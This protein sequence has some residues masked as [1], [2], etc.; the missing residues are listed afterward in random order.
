MLKINQSI[1]QFTLFFSRCG[2]TTQIPQ[3]ILDASLNGPAEQVANVLCTQPR[4]ISAITVAQRV[5]QERAESLG[6]S[7]GY[8]IRLESV[9]VPKHTRSPGFTVALWICNLPTS[10]RR[11]Q[12]EMKAEI[13]TFFSPAVVGHQAA[14]LH[15]RR[16][17]E[18][19]GGWC[20]P[21]GGHARHR[22]WGAR[23][24]RGEVSVCFA[25]KSVVVCSGLLKHFCFLH[26]SLSDFLLLVLKDLIIKRPDL[27]IVLMSATLNANL[28]SE[29]FYNCPTVHIPGLTSSNQNIH[30][31][32]NL[33]LTNVISSCRT[34]IPRW[35]VLP[36]RRHC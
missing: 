28:F 17:A 1:I 4:R 18:K 26:F 31:N 25:R 12:P 6:N 34:H 29:Y 5:A 19:T 3:F 14:V 9:K 13:K 8:Q 32:W 16:S 35:S 33:F 2:K 27:K 36:R 24:N 11:T 21:Q 15:H 10:I 22:G 7:V 23:A 20:R 30:F